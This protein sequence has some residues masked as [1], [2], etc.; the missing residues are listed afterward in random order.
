M[1]WKSHPLFSSK[2]KGNSSFCKAL[3]PHRTRTKVMGCLQQPR[4]PHYNALVLWWGSTWELY[5]TFNGGTREL[6]IS[7]HGK[8]KE[9]ETGDGRLMETNSFVPFAIKCTKNCLDMHQVHSNRKLKNNKRDFPYSCSVENRIL[10]VGEN[11]YGPGRQLI[12]HILESN[13]C[14]RFCIVV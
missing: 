9:K 11:A 8:R 6:G 3:F 13:F 10:A 5:N 12:L 2:R 4:H 14:R 1:G 7:F